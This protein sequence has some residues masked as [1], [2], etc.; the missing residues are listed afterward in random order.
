MKW[1]LGV[2]AALALSLTSCAATMTLSGHF[3]SLEN[4]ATSC[5]VPPVFAAASSG[6]IVTV[7]FSWTGPEAGRD[8]VSG[9]VGSAFYF[10]RPTQAGSYTIRA[11]ARDAMFNYNCSDS[12]ITAVYRGTPDKVRDLRQ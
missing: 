7:V 12:S 6:D 2:A 3:P 8:S 10:S 9:T 4:R 5:A 1:L 11:A